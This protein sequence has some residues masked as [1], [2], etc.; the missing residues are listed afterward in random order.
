MNF[1]LIAVLIVVLL[2]L[3]YSLVI[4]KNRPRLRAIVASIG[5]VISLAVVFVGIVPLLVLLSIAWKYFPGHI[6]AEDWFS[7]LY[8]ALV[9]E[10]VRF[11][12][13]IT[14]EKI[15]ILLLKAKRIDP[16]FVYVFKVFVT[17]I[18]LLV[19]PW[20]L[21]HTQW[22]PS[23]VFLIAGLQTLVDFFLDKLTKSPPT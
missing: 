16:S 8:V 14:A 9:T 3:L 12:Y 7:I 2:G 15:M 4:E 5:A 20:L 19:V 21:L 22:S 13:E 17:F 18:L 11:I 23:A 10:A 6:V 1:V